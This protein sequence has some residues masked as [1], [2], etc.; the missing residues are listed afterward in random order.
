ME[1]KTAEVIFA[2]CERALA[3]LT[4]L[5]TAIAK[6]SDDTE[7]QELMYALSGAIVELHSGVRAPVVRQYRDLQKID[8]ED[9]APYEPTDEEIEQMRSA[10]GEIEMAVDT[11]ILRECTSQWQKVAKIVGDLIPEFEQV[12]AELPIAYIQARMGELE[13]SGKI[14]LVGNVWSMRYS[15]TRLAQDEAS[16][17]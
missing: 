5:E 1:R 12:C 14:E 2:A 6:I 3:S 13:N 7:Q 15:E 10:S 16:A 8:P 4:E 9:A 17:A 11:M